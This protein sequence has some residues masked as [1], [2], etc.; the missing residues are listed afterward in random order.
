MSFRDVQKAHNTHVT[1]LSLATRQR[2]RLQMNVK[3]IANNI[4]NSS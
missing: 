3:V 1:N 2:V 4:N